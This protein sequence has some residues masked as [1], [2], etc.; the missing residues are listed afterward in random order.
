MSARGPVMVP[1]NWWIAESPE[2]IRKERDRINTAY[3]RVK[4]YYHTGDETV[5]KALDQLHAL[6][7][8]LN[9]AVGPHEVDTCWD[10]CPRSE[11]DEPCSKATA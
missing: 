3:F 11:D 6:W 8:T 5:V 4:K 1:E 9:R 2:G 10:A 7:H